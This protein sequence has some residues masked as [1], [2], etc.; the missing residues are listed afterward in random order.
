MFRDLLRAVRDLLATTQAQTRGLIAFFGLSFL[1]IVLLVWMP[2]RYRRGEDVLSAAD[3]RRL[4][5]LYEQMVARARADSIAAL[6]VR[7][8]FPFDPNRASVDSLQMLGFPGYL[9][10]RIDNYRNKGGRFR[11]RGDLKNIYG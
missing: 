2:G 6:P 9:A 10:R 7:K 4:D 1:V 8:R 11:T 3:Q 5:S